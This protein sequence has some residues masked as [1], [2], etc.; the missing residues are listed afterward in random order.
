MPPVLRQV[1]PEEQI[2]ADII[3]LLHQQFPHLQD[4]SAETDLAAAGVLDSLSLMDLIVGIESQF[5][6]TLP[7]RA[8]QP[9]HFK[10]VESIT[11]LVQQ[12]I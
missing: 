8:I 11:Q 7:P 6:I 12:Q 2:T 3:E 9:R 1:K 10:S 5:Q 4:L